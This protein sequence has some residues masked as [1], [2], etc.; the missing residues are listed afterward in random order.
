MGLYE[1][2]TAVRDRCVTHDFL[3]WI[4]PSRADWDVQAAGKV[5]DMVLQLAEQGNFKLARKLVSI[6]QDHAYFAEEEPDD[7]PLDYVGYPELFRH[8]N[9][10]AP[11]DLFALADYPP[12]RHFADDCELAERID[13]FL[14]AL[15]GDKMQTALAEDCRRDLNTLLVLAD[16]CEEHNMPMAAAEARHL[17]HLTRL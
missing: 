1:F 5:A 17:P 15:R 10:Q 2:L 6:F 12:W 9:L 7:E 3:Q 11:R 14:V 16:W 4:T 8:L 13:S